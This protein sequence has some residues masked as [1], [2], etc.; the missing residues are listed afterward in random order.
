M[1]T[2]HSLASLMKFA[3][4]AEWADAFEDVL[5]EHFGMAFE[6]FDLEQ[7]DIPNLLGQHWAGT[8]WGCAFEDFLTRRVGPDGRNVVEDYLKRR[9][10][11]ETGQ[12][13]RYMGALSSS[14]M[15]LYEVSDIVVGE[16]FLARD[17]I[18]GGEPVLIHERSATQTL[19]NGTGSARDW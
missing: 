17:L 14:F 7:D 11:K 18:L 10:W 2:G 15:S 3:I 6:A 19:R 1:N 13:Q 16:S 8:L 12:T 5:A 9:G 4:R